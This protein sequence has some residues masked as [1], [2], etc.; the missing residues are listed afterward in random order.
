MKRKNYKIGLHERL[1]DP[2][3]AAGYLEDVLVNESNE[4]FLIALKDII[5]A[6]EENIS[7]LSSKAGITR[8]TLYQALS[9]TGNPRLSTITELLKSVGLHL[10]VIPFKDEA[11]RKAS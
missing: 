5:E 10:S 1:K 11:D 4:A 9:K 7:A 3:Y 8:Q 2:T 6:R